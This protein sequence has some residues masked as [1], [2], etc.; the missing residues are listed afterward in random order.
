MNDQYDSGLDDGYE[1]SSNR[2]NDYIQLP[3]DAPIM[4]WRHGS[5]GS[6]KG[7]S[8][9]F[10]R[11]TSGVPEY[12]K[13][14]ESSGLAV[15]KSFETHVN[16]KT[17]KEYQLYAWR[18]LI[19][20][21]IASRKRWF[22]NANSGK[23]NS[24]IQTLAILADKRDGELIATIPAMLSA[25]VFA[26]D[27][28]EKLIAEWLEYAKSKDAVIPPQYFWMAV[29]TFGD[30]QDFVGPKHTSTLPTLWV[31]EKTLPKFVGNETA[32]KMK[33]IKEEALLWLHDKKWLSGET[34][35]AHATEQQ[36]DQ[37]EYNPG[38]QD[39]SIPF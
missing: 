12:D 15:P 32:R 33:T 31:N 14:A 39:N 18:S 6:E 23:K 16:S 29:G 1:T 21:P 35:T 7:S 10:G 8:K 4:A 36:P 37:P 27:K 38:Y 24:H 13:F 11:W 19:F 2:K 20:A 25:K 26:G 34:D 5:I 9:Y 3:F 17:G 22:V 30:A 28:F